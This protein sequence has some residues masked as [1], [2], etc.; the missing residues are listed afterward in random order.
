MTAVLLSPVAVRSTHDQPR[1]TAQRLRPRPC[2]RSAR[3]V[4]IVRMG[5]EAARGATGCPSN[6]CTRRSVGSF[7]RTGPRTPGRRPHLRK[8]VR[9]AVRGAGLF[10]GGSAFRCRLSTACGD[11]GRPWSMTTPPPSP[12]AKRT[13]PPRLAALVNQVPA[14]GESWRPA[15]VVHR[16]LGSV[17]GDG[18]PQGFLTGKPAD[19]YSSGSL[20]R[21]RG[22]CPAWPLVRVQAPRTSVTGARATR[23]RLRLCGRSGS[24]RARRRG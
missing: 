5:A 16:R 12:G 17:G 24:P 3:Q 2:W 21:R 14:R 7:L 11:R 6:T 18:P 13:G 15:S 19:A 1:A 4:L 10:R 20:P 9:G 23:W 22:L 8:S